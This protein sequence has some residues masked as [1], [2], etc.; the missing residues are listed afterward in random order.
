MARNVNIDVHTV[1]IETQEGQRIARYE[2]DRIGAGFKFS[3]ESV[4]QLFADIWETMGYTWGD[5]ICLNIVERHYA[6]VVR[7]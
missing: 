5:S 2:T 6:K 7:S 3:A 4:P 1:I